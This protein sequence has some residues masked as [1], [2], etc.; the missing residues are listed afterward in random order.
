MANFI[1]QMVTMQT[2]QRELNYYELGKINH[3]G[4]ILCVKS[5]GKWPSFLPFWIWSPHPKVDRLNFWPFKC[6]KNL[7][8][9]FPTFFFHLF[10][11]FNPKRKSYKDVGISF[12]LGQHHCHHFVSRFFKFLFVYFNLFCF[13]FFEFFALFNVMCSSSF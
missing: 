13:V 8:V 5:L 12:S 3:L 6:I 1:K 11:S 2:W 10:I 4:S 7:L 9:F